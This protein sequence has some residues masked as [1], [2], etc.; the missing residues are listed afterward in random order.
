M[1]Y[2]QKR[3]IKRGELLTSIKLERQFFDRIDA[4]A[5][6]TGQRWTDLVRAILREKPQGQSNASWLRV[7][8]LEI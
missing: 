8:L 3:S 1:Q 2:L 5:A 4:A 6:A 7:S